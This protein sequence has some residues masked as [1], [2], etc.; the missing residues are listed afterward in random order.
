MSRL[1]ADD[2]TFRPATCSALTID[3]ED[4]INILM[5]DVF[6][7]PMEPT[8]R[9]IDNVQNLLDLFQEN[10]TKATFY[11]LGE[12]ALS[13]P[14]LVKKIA[15]QGHEIGVHGYHHDQIFRLTPQKAREDLKKAKTLIEDVSGCA[16]YGFRAPA[17]SIDEKTSWCLEILS[18]LGFKYDSSIMPAKAN[19]YGWPDFPKEIQQLNLKNGSTLIEV[20]LSVTHFIG[21]TIPA[22]GGGYLRY[23]PYRFTQKAFTAIQQSRPVIVYLHPY[24]IDTVRYPDYFYKA[25]ATLP[26]KKKLPLSIYRLNKGTVKRKLDLLMKEFPFKPVIEIIQDLEGEHKI[27]V[28]NL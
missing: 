13:F 26:L 8:T 7:T 19:R 4:G 6:N 27:P 15:S 18:E 2:P 11:I 24:E 9:V 21:R 28:R 17:F 22:C 20:P 12:I 1:P 5:Q 14:D 3:V 16:V 25:K 23:F 10:H